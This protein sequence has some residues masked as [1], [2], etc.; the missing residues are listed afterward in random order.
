MKKIISCVCFGECVRKH[1]IFV[2]SILGMAQLDLASI[3]G[4]VFAFITVR[5]T[6]L[7]VNICLST[8]SLPEEWKIYT[9]SYQLIPKKGGLTLIKNYRPISLLCMLSKI[10]ERIV[11]NH[12]IDFIRP[13]LSTNQFG[14]LKGRSCLS[15]L[16]TSYSEIVEAL[17][18]G[19]SC[20]VIYLD[21]AKAFDK[22]SHKQLL[23]KLWRLGITG[24][25]W[26]WFECYLSNRS[27]YVCLE[28]TNSSSLSVLS[29]VPQG[30]ILGP[31]LFL[32]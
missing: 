26:K 31:L 1:D 18:A 3:Q 29:G 28:G 12:I 11:Y 17:N 24:N 27:H 6:S 7:T 19:E 4:R 22:V 8:G 14:F 30:S 15:Q 9:R 5:L 20:D 13:Q 2:A 21:F 16:L 25:V 23:F 32:V 10:L